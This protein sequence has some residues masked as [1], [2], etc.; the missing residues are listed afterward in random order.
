MCE[1][2]FSYKWISQL[3]ISA[4]AFALVYHIRTMIYKIFDGYPNPIH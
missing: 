1:Y 4:K 3:C 2:I